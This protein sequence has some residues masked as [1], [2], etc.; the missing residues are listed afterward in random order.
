[1]IVHDDAVLKAVARVDV[2]AIVGMLGGGVKKDSVQVV[3]V[4]DTSNVAN[5]VG[6]VMQ[7]V[8][9][10]IVVVVVSTTFRRRA[11]RQQ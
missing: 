3:V 9:G 5:A 1:M 11:H 8:Y 10:R 6:W 2:I 4:T 7:V